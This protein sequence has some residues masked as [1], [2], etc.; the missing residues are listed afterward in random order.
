VTPNPGRA[1]VDEIKVTV[2]RITGDEDSLCTDGDWC[3]A[4][5]SVEGVPGRF[6]VGKE[7]TDPAVRAALAK[8]VGPGETVTWTPPDLITEV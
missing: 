3:P 2:L 1:Y 7:V 5:L 4:L 6:V 8:F